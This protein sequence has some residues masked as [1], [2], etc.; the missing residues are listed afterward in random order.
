MRAPEVTHES[1]WKGKLEQIFAGRLGT[2]GNGNRR[3]QVR[4]EVN[5][6]RDD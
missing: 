1:P 3:D 2:G 5:T 6:G 4:V